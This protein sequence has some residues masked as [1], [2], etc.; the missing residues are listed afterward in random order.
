MKQ[1]Q[2]N[3]NYNA[4]VFFL[5]LEISYL[6]K[7][8]GIPNRI[9]HLLTDSVLF[10]KLIL[11]IFFS[12]SQSSMKIFA[13]GF[14]IWHIQSCLCTTKTQ[15]TSFLIFLLLYSYFY[16]SRHIHFL[17]A[18]IYYYSLSAKHMPGILNS[19][20]VIL[21]ATIFYRNNFYFMSII[22]LN[23]LNILLLSAVT[24]SLNW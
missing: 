23:E 5:F 8:H 12:I 14:L 22:K 2:K 21:T 13:F 9:I 20:T 10:I 7:Q 11:D 17:R 4:K 16:F 15:K 1:I 6:K 3:F 19:S 24:M 18:K